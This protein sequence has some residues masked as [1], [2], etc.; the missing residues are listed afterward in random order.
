MY[1]WYPVKRN[2]GVHDVVRLLKKTKRVAVIDP[3]TYKVVQVISRQLVVSTI[4]GQKFDREADFYNILPSTSFG[5][6]TVHSVTENASVGAL[7]RKM[8]EK[9]VSASTCRTIIQVICSNFVSSRNSGRQ[10]CH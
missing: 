2:A 1:P 10:R 7:Y 8:Y 4:L 3:K 9:N 6:K 5:L